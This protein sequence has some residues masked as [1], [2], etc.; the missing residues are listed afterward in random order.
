MCDP[1][2]IP[3]LSR[4]PKLASQFTDWRY[5]EMRNVVEFCIDNDPNKPDFLSRLIDEGVVRRECGTAE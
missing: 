4:A 3:D 1:D 2:F 5:K